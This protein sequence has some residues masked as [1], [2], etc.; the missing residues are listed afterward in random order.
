MMKILFVNA[1][2]RENSRT[3]QLAHYVL[4]H[5]SGEVIEIQL[6][7]EALSPLNRETLKERDCLLSQGTLGDEMFRYARQFAD[8]DLIV[9]AAPYWELGFPALLKIYME[10]ITVNR[11][12]FQYNN[13]I[14]EGL[15][16]A[17]KLIY[18]TTAGGPIIADFG[19]TYMKTMA[20]TFYGI[21]ETVC[22]QAEN[23]DV[24]GVDIE[25]I[26][27]ETKTDIK[28]YMDNMQ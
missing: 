16:K 9:M 5:L 24:D 19:Y 26:L 13:G 8:A 14:P 12:V 6:E 4:E 23:L 20:E 1:C 25:A 15:C 22:F 7:N 27:E 2:V 28:K 10:Q 18:I 17:R 11:I 21:R 3:L